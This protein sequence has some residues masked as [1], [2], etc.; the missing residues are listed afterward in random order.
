[1]SLIVLP[2]ISEDSYLYT[3]T[4]VILQITV[5]FKISKRDI[6]AKVHDNIT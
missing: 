6:V 5:D 4:T 1:M 2:K 3:N